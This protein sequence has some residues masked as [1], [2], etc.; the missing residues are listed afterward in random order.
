MSSSYKRKEKFNRSLDKDFT[1]DY[2]TDTTVNVNNAFNVKR[3]WLPTDVAQITP[4]TE[5]QGKLCYAFSEGRHIVGCGSSGSG[6]SF[7]SMY[8]SLC[9]VLDHSSRQDH[10]IL[11]RSAVPT[12]DLGYLPG[13]LEDKQLVYE[14]PYIEIAHE[15]LGKESAY[16]DL[17]K[18]GVIKFCTT[19][20]IRSLSFHNAIIIIDEAQNMTFH[21]L[22]SV[23]TRLGKESRLIV[24][25]DTKQTDLTTHRSSSNV[26]GFATFLDVASTMSAFDIVEF[27]YKDIVR[28]DFVKSWIMAVENTVQGKV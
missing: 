18:T 8:L 22:N 16:D 19:S 28:S 27:T 15:L 1:M 24:I 7:L 9:V 11:V 14:L 3:N 5:S 10:I 23:V 25:G 13:N 12:R 20:F 21:E 17:K 6:K 4:M 26:S 2:R